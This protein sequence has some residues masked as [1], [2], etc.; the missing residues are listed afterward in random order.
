MRTTSRAYCRNSVVKQFLLLFL[1]FQD[2]IFREK[3]CKQFVK[4]YPIFVKSGKTGAQNFINIDSNTTNM[5]V[6]DID[7]GTRSLILTETE[8]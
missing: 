3:K 5:V 8:R 6:S 1:I 2:K 4:C 7:R